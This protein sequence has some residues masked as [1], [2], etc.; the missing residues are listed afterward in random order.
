MKGKE[1]I[2]ILGGGN[3]ALA[4][5]AFLGLQGLA[6]RLW[7]FPEFREG[8]SH[9]YR[10]Q[11]IRSFGKLEGEVDVA[12]YEDLREALQGATLIMAVVPAFAHGRLAE[13]VAP[14]ISEDAVLILNPGRTGGA[15]EVGAILHRHGKHN[16]VVETQTLLFACRKKGE[17]SIQFNG[18]KDF[19]RVGVFPSNKTDGVMDR[20]NRILPRFRKVPDILTTSLGNIGAMFHPA[21]ALLN[22]GILE[23]GKPYDYY[24]ATMTPGVAGIMEQADGE[25]L[26]IA[27]AA[28]AEVFSA[29]QWLHE[30]YRVEDSSLY[31]MLL[32]NSAYQG[33]AGPSVIQTRYIT[34]DVP[35][36]LVPMEAFGSLLQIGTPTISTLIQLANLLLRED[37]RKSGRNL[38]R[39]G[40]KGMTPEEVK[41]LVREGFR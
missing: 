5:S 24:R 26:K 19:I 27:G 35:T 41:E 4:F 21:S 31:Q 36:G 25:R 29:C 10:T 34:E 32:R 38:D 2:V 18:I 11:R 12:C 8:L 33:I 37:F 15:L 30:S 6:P 3:G 40:L 13:E 39:L 17:D 9:L 16:P 23:S 14:H 1:Q 22:V 20:L 28:G 7:E